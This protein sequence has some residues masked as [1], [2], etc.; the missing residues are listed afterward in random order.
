[1]PG[2]RDYDT[3]GFE[4]CNY[5][6]PLDDTHEIVDFGDGEFVV[7]K[8]AISLLKALNEAGLRIR[9]HHYTG[10]SNSFISILLGN[11]VIIEVRTVDEKDAIRTKYNGTKELLI[12]R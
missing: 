12:R 2:V 11:N 9:T 8:E 1:M 6:H 3:V 4:Y 10:G 7:N 5:H